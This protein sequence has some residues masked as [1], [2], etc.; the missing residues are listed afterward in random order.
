MENPRLAALRKLIARYEKTLADYTAIDE[1]IRSLPASATL[2]EALRVNQEIRYGA[3]RA[4]DLARE[5]L[6]RE[7]R[8]DAASPAGVNMFAQPV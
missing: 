4:L 5:R 6:G 2:D 7:Q 1:E 3:R 8:A